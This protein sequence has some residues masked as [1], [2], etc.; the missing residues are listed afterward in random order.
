LIRSRLGRAGQRLRFAAPALLVALALAFIP[1]PTCIIRLAAGQPCPA[2]GLTR[3]ALALARLDLAAA[4]TWNPLAIP[5]ALAALGGLFG[6][7]ML[8]DRAWNGF[9]RDI[10][11]GSAVA[12][13]VV[14]ALRF[15]GLFGG[16]VP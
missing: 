16:P 8:D 9:V 12:I 11:G 3:A 15:F 2:C 13:V 4:T 1:Y 10:G 5:L 6:A 7:V 14:W